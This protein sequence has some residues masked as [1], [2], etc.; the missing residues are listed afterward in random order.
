[1]DVSL[2]DSRRTSEGN[3]LFVS[4]LVLVDVSLEVRDPVGALVIIVVSILVLV[5]VS[6]ED[7]FV[8][9]LH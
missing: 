9:M 8:L 4:I 3:P 5:D 1:V 7:V 6:L 2:E